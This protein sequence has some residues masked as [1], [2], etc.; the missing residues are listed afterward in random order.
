M[1]ISATLC[2]LTRVASTNSVSWHLVQSAKRLLRLEDLS[3]DVL[4]LEKEDAWELLGCTFP[5]LLRCA[6][7]TWDD[8]WS[9]VKRNDTLDSFLLRHPLLKQLQAQ[10]P[11]IK[12]WP[13][14]TA[15]LP[16]LDL[17]FLRC[18]ARVVPSILSSGLKRADLSWN[19]QD[20][21]SEIEGMVVALKSLTRSD[22]PFVLSNA[23]GRIFEHVMDSVSRNIPYTK[24]LRFSVRGVH[25]RDVGIFHAAII[26]TQIH[27]ERT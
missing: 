19:E 25:S 12:A 7:R 4:L 18:Q 15:Q 20:S 5:R 8:Y 23:C 16:L 27:T 1:I 22:V 3:I 11:V 21:P 13:S 6:I 24:I 10:G 26:F 2:S 14:T 17:Q 9:S